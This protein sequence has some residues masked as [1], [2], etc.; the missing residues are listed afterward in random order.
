[1]LTGINFPHL[2]DVTTEHQAAQQLFQLDDPKIEYVK[3]S[4]R[5]DIMEVHMMVGGVK[6][7]TFAA[8]YGMSSTVLVF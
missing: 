4:R 2:D 7:L 1:L 5:S 6:Q 8:A 3:Q